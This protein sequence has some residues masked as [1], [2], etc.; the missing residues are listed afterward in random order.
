MKI[1]YLLKNIVLILILV[2]C[3]G[4]AIASDSYKMLVC[5]GCTYQQKKSK[6]IVNFKPYT[7]VNVQVADVLNGTVVAFN[8]YH[9]VEPGYSNTDIYNVSPRS[10][11]IAATKKANKILSDMRKSVESDPELRNR[12]R[13]LY[14]NLTAICP[15]LVF[16]LMLL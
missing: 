13:D 14:P 15:L 10:D 1:D 4:K 6:A 5:N 12:V 16:L 9:E 2:M 8:V 7:T 3:S 11:V